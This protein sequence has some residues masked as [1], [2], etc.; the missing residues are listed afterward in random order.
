MIQ[1]FE[2]VHTTHSGEGER[3]QKNNISD[4]FTVF[5]HFHQYNAHSYLSSKRC[6]HFTPLFRYIIK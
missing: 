5:Q 4:V 1:P 2:S 6:R 3:V